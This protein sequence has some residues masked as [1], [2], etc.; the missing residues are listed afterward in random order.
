MASVPFQSRAPASEWLIAL[1]GFAVMFLPVYWWAANGI[2][3]T[4]EQAHGAIILL[5]FC[6][7]F[8]D[9]R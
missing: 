4:D 5:A 2:W 7:L 9:K 1:A 3:Q 8:S 6:W